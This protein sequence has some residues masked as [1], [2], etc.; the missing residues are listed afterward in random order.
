MND[1]TGMI[2]WVSYNPTYKTDANN[3]FDIYIC[4]E[5]GTCYFQHKTGKLL[6]QEEFNEVINE[7]E[8]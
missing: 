3:L 4:P 6:T 5:K 7:L 1:I 8:H 2:Y